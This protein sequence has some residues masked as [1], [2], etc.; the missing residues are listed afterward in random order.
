MMKIDGISTEFTKA[1]SSSGFIKGAEVPDGLTGTEPGVVL[2]PDAAGLDV[3]FENLIKEGV[4]KIEGPQKVLNE[5]ISG[6]LQGKE[7][8]HNV[9][10]AAEQARFSMNFTVKVR[11]R[12]IEAYQTIMRMQV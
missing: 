9:M 8:L 12:I 1:I 5:K 6:F 10:I 2:S 3:D 11:D 4:E 7:Q